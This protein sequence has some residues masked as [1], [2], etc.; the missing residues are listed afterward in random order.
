MIT[1][2]LTSVKKNLGLDESYEFFDDDIL[3]LING[4]F[5]TLNQL[6][7][8]PDDGFSI[9]DKTTTWDAYLNGD[10]RLESLKTFV[11]LK[12]RL[13]FDPPATSFAIDAFNKQAE[14]LLWRLSVVREGDEWT[15]PTLVSS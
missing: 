7:L 15:D 1:S 13:A 8:G 2:I 4:V 12:V 9:S 10:L 6:G 5:A 14:E 3:L 11:F